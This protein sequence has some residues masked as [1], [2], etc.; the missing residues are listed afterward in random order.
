MT[1]SEIDN[2]RLSVEHR[3]ETLGKD[4]SAVWDMLVLNDPRFLY[5]MQFMRAQFQSLGLQY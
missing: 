1:F 3:A 2:A 4:V 5:R